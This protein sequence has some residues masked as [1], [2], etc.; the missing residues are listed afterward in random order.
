MLPF[1]NGVFIIA[2]KAN[3]PIAVIALSGTEKISKNPFRKNRVKLTVAEVISADE[4][5]AL[6]TSEIGERVKSAIEAALYEAE[7]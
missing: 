4:V 6:S 1:H 5:Q 3:V 7:E 2:Q